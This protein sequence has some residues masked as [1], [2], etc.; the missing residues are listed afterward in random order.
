MDYTTDQN[1]QAAIQVV[2]RNEGGYVNDP[3]DAGGSTNMGISQKTYPNLDIVNLT[4]D[5]ASQIYYRDWWTHFHYDQITNSNLATKVFD[6]AVNIGAGRS[7]KILQRCLNVNGFPSM[8]DDGDLG[9]MSIK[10]INSCDA[11]TI[12]TAF[13]AAQANY[14][15]A[16]VQAHPEDQEFLNGW[17][18]RAA[19]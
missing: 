1:F 12:L 2:L 15:R 4:K 8:I 9:P 6:T 14:Y 7:N 13:R 10:A 18:N 5:Q 17:L 11:P 3:N 19:S 16:V